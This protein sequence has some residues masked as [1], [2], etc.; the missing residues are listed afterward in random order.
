MN[1]YISAILIYIFTIIYF[2]LSN[3]T[4]HLYTIKYYSLIENIYDDK[5]SLIELIN[6]LAIY[7][8]IIRYIRIHLLFS[9]LFITVNFIIKLSLIAK[10]IKYSMVLV[11]ILVS[12]DILSLKAR[13]RTLEDKLY[14]MYYNLK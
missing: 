6:H 11:I 12:Y 8:V 2:L 5:K 10:I 14:R 4:M 7:N 13:L 3:K 1:T 9:S